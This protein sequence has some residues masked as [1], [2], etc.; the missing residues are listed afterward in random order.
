MKDS[1]D[2]TQFFKRGD[3]PEAVLKTFVDLSNPVLLR[4][5][6]EFT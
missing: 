1:K 3:G 6:A 4:N 2:S 5:T